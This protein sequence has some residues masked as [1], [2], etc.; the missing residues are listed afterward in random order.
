MTPKRFFFVLLCILAVGALGLTQTNRW[1][2]Q[3]L[4]ILRSLNL[5]QLKAPPSDP[6][7]RVA[8]DPAAAR[9]GHKFFFD[10]RFSG[11]GEVSCATCHDPTKGF[12]DQLPLA[13]GMG[14]AP[15]NTPTIVGTAHNA[16]YFWDG[17]ADSLWAQA[18][19]PLEAAPEHGTNRMHV[20]RLVETH[21]RAEYEN[22]FGPLPNA[23]NA[24]RF[25][26][27]EGAFSSQNVQ[28][29]WQNLPDATQRAVN[30]VFVNVGKAIAA[31]ERRINPGESRFDA[32]LNAM[33]SSGIKSNP[34]FTATE[35]KGLELFIGK[36]GCVTC[37]SG[38]MF[39]DGQFHNVGVPRNRD[40]ETDDLGRINALKPLLEGDFTCKSWLSDAPKQCDK[41]EQ[42]KTQVSSDD[43]Q[44]LGLKAFKT[45]T[46]RNVAQTFPFMHAG[47]FFKLRQVLEHY[48]N[49]PNAQESGTELRALKLS[50]SELND[51]EA[52]LKTLDAPPNAAA[53]FLK[54]PFVQ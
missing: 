37:H 16:W 7:N 41:L 4:Y 8:D 39:T 31:Y 32:Y 25:P 1:S 53:A 42:F 43:E 10:L 30:R 11:N 35:V 3:E 48:S 5:K 27:L 47:Q 26:R 46:L 14:T 49:M 22:V 54:N 51:L 17:R 44:I 15:R 29:A 38:P 34:A 20:A 18:L 33:D 52:F 12:T 40:L 2:S 36:A 28:E 21:Y 24:T 6:T 23:I 45:P 19:G 9:L 13:E 50:T